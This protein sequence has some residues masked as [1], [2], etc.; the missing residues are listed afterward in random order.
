MCIRDRL[1]SGPVKDRHEVVAYQM[2]VF[3]SQ[4]FQSLDIVVNVHVSLG[5]TCL[6][7]V[8]D[9]DALDTGNVKS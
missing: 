4:V 7:G 6:D 2:N 9:V 5:R 8:M 1:C 3:F